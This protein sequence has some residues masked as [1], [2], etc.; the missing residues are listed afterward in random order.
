M[1]NAFTQLFNQLKTRERIIDDL[2]LHIEF[3]NERALFAADENKIYDRY[4]RFQDMLTELVGLNCSEAISCKRDKI[5]TAERYTDYFDIQGKE[6]TIIIYIV[7]Y[8]D[9]TVFRHSQ[10][11]RIGTVLQK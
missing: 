9:S 10:T 6:N 3:K 1:K 4:E 2:E 11:F 5:R 7:F 8:L